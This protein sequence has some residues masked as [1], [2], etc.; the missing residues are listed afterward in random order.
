MRASGKTALLVTMIAALAGWVTACT[1]V[2]RT[3]FGNMSFSTE[4]LLGKVIWHDLIT[5]DVD[6]AR[7]FYGGLF[8]WTFEDSTGPGGD[9]YVL[10]R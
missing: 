3:D 10:A 1:A 7:E 8:G 4:P 9:D 6:A 2:S 5:E